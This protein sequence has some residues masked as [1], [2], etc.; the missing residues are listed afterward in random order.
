MDSPPD[1][2]IVDFPGAERTAY[3]DA[4]KRQRKAPKTVAAFDLTFSAP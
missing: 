2:F 1:R 4:L 3:I